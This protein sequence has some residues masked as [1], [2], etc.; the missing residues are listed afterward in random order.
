[1]VSDQALLDARE[2]CRLLG[3]SR[4]TLWRLRERRDFPIPIQLS[5]RRIAWRRDA[6]DAWLEARDGEGAP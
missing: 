4:T 2:V 3:I 6:I 5:I 1:M